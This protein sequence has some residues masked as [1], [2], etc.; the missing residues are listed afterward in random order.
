MYQVLFH[1]DPFEPDPTTRVLGNTENLTQRSKI[2]TYGRVV[3]QNLYKRYTPQMLRWL[4]TWWIGSA[5]KTPDRGEAGAHPGGASPPSY[6]KDK[7][8]LK[9]WYTSHWDLDY[10]SREDMDELARRT[11]SSNRDKESDDSEDR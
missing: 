6:H 3:F 2:A 1:L 9:D 7:R 10:M 11:Q 8:A 4:K 5:R